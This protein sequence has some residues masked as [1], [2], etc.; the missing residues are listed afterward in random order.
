MT[1]VLPENQGNL[2]NLAALPTDADV[3]GELRTLNARGGDGT[4]SLWQLTLEEDEDDDWGAGPAVWL[5]AGTAGA[6]GALRWVDRSGVFIPA[7]GIPR[8]SEQGPTVPYFDWSGTAC[9]VHIALRVPIEHVF[10]AVAEVVRVR[11]RPT[12]VEWAEVDRH[13]RLIGPPQP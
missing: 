8:L 11:Q 6:S 7:E 2:I 10:A 3:V 4:P 9:T 5:D 12:S 1:P 13:H